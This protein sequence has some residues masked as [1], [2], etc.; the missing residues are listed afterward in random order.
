MRSDD[1][2]RQVWAAYIRG[3]MRASGLR[4]PALAQRL[5]VDPSTVWRWETGK[6]KPESPV[7]PEAIAKLF[8][9]DVD[10]VL[11]AAGLV[12]VAPTPAVEERREPDEERE[13]IMASRASPRMKAIML[14]RLEELRRQDEARIEQQRRLDKERR[15]ETLRFMLER[16]G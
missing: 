2:P 10:E 13:L 14:H 4:G 15:M 9:L 1:D 3:L 12:P 5:G 16:A 11:M 8:Q 6:Q 7:M